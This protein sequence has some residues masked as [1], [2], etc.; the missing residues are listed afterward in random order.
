M[1]AKSSMSHSEAISKKTKKI[2]SDFGRIGGKKLAE[3]RGSKYY[4]KIAKARWRKERNAKN[5]Q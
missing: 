1:R 2:F 4:S 3:K 5:H